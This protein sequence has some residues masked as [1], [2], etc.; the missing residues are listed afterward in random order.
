[1]LNITYL[2]FVLDIFYFVI[3]AS[4]DFE[5]ISKEDNN[6]IV[7]Y[8]LLHSCT[9]YAVYQGSS[10]VCCENKWT[11]RL[12]YKSKNDNICITDTDKNVCEY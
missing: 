6:E 4:D 10:F 12:Q 2:L 9:E 7:T 5:I 8:Y 3:N 11:I 1:M